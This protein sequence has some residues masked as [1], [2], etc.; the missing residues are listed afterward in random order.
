MEG[1]PERLLFCCL[2]GFSPSAFIE[3]DLSEFCSDDGLIPMSSAMEGDPL[4]EMD[5]CLVCTCLSDSEFCSREGFK[6]SIAAIEGVPLLCLPFAWDSLP[7]VGRTLISSA[8]DSVPDLDVR[9]G[10]AEASA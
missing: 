6:P 10:S 3:G 7:C 1:V 5:F 4:A 2:T 9:M 8:M